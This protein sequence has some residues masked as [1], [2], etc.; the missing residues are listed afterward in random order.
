MATSRVNRTDRLIWAK[1]MSAGLNA[2][3]SVRNLTVGE[4]IREHFDGLTP[5]EH[6]AVAQELETIR[7][8]TARLRELSHRIKRTTS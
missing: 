6:D 1:T 4:L 5:R 3:D 2:L 8:A 7:A